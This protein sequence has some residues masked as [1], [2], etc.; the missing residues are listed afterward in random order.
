MCKY[1]LNRETTKSEEK[2]LDDVKGFLSKKRHS[3]YTFVLWK[4]SLKL[5]FT[6]QSGPKTVETITYL[7]I[8]FH[9]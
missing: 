1:V 4:K 7:P 3:K 2:E 9:T 5:D 6:S 8:S